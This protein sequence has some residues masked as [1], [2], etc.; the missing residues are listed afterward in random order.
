[1]P[2]IYL[3]VSLA[4]AAL[5]WNVLRPTYAPG[6]RAFTSFMAGWLTG[7]L[8]LHHIAW[9]VLATVGFALGG[10]LSAWPGW[11][12]LLISL[13]SWTGLG[14]AALEADRAGD[15]LERALREGLGRD[16]E[17]AIDP[18]QWERLPRRMPWRRIAV[19]FP[20]RHPEVE[21]IR[22]IRYGRARG[23]DLYLDVYRPR[24]R[25][26]GC[27]TLLQVH[28]GGWVVGSK[29]QQA[30]P[31]LHHL[32]AQGWVCVSADYRLSPHATFPDHLID[33]KRAV[34]WIREHGAEHGADPGFLIVTGGSAGAHLAAL[35]ALTANDPE[36][37][38]GFEDV[39]TNVSGCVPFYGIYDLA[40]RD[41]LWRHDDLRR[42]LERQVMKASLAEAPREYE[43]ASP[44]AHV[45]LDAPP[46]FILHGARD[47]CAPVEGARRF[48]A[49]LRAKSQAPVVYA[50][51]PGAQHAFDMFPSIRTQHVVHAVERFGVYLHG[52]QSEARLDLLDDLDPERD[53][54]GEA[55]ERSAA[56]P[57]DAV[58][59]EPAHAG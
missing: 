36:Y 10:A 16:Y 22:D 31:L 4:G 38:P 2:W 55:E 43:R 45:A 26:T 12:G 29:N 15:A 59:A 35:L 32:A 50:E 27:P 40:D 18:A 58:E 54:H 24:R 8:P 11:L 33:L 23:I 25:R 28:G 9:Q 21:R 49:A 57:R 52:T 6:R 1:M 5:T 3:V 7:E 53:E 20:I 14:Y 44:I 19:P 17:S 46:F 13:G 42:L 48:A 56:G 41:R 37:Q 39:D 30:L 51:L 47:S 34:A